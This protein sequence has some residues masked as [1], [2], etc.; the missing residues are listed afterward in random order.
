MTPFYDSKKCI[1][2][3]K[4]RPVLI[5]GG[6]RN[7][8]YTILPVSTITRKENIDPDFDVKV[9]PEQYPNINL[10]RI[11]YIRTHKQTIVHQSSLSKEI[12]DLK[13]EY[14]ELYLLVLEKLEEFNKR[15]MDDAF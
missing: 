1:N 11:S 5:I 8:D 4:R 7:N 12:G 2:S 10:D 14:E 9:E 13:T 15:M 3:F 6:P